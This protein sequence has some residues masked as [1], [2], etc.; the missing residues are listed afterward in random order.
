MNVPSEPIDFTHA[1][2]DSS[3]LIPPH[4]AQA[5]DALD[6]RQAQEWAKL[7]QLDG[8]ARLMDAQFSIPFT[9]LRVGLDTLIGLIPGIG[10]TISLAVAGYIIFDAKQLGAD[11]AQLLR[12][13]LNSFIDWVIGLVPVVG[14]LIDIGWQSNLRN[15]RYLRDI[16]EEKWA[17]ERDALLKR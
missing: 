4:L 6:E 3:Q 1:Q 14:D 12:M 17:K 11:S 13:V 2:D 5:L 10:D 16:L 7:N 15:T 9:S 8:I